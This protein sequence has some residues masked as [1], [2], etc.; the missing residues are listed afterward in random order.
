LKIA[1][2]I[3]LFSSGCTMEAFAHY[4][5]SKRRMEESGEKTLSPYFLVFSEHPE[6]DRLP[7]KEASA[8]VNIIG[9]IADVTVMQK[10][11]NSGK[12]TL[13][14]IYT[15]PLSTKAAVYAMKM[16]IGKRTITARISE[17]EKPGNDYNAAKQN[18]NRV[19]LL[20]QNRPNVFTLNCYICQPSILIF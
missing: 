7:L 16:T 5:R 3:I 1:I 11:V 14:A 8:N 19:C 4:S 9:V 2:L 6:T 15:F 17:K 18:G 12:N 20:E 13:E 10:Y